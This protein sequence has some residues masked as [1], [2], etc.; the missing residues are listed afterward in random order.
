MKKFSLLLINIV[1]VV[2]SVPSGAR[3]VDQ[4]AVS[5]NDEIVLDSDVADFKKKLVSKSFKELFGGID[6]SALKDDRAILEL[7]IEERI[8]NQ[9]VKK[10]ELEATPQE[11]EGQIRS[12]LKRNGI[13]ENQLK[14]RLSQLGTTFAEYHN[15]IKRQL[16][17]NNLIGREIKPTLEISE[18]QL[19]HYFARSSRNNSYDA[20]FKIAHILVTKKGNSNVEPGARAQQLW[21]IVSKDPSQFQKHVAE[22]SDDTSTL[23][24]G[25]LLG[26]FPLSQLNKEF[27]AEVS[28]TPVGQV[29][30]PIKTSAGYHIILVMEKRAADFSVLSKEQKDALRNEMVSTELEKKMALWLER[31][32]TESHIKR[33]LN[34]AQ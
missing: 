9:Q 4:V 26:T 11:V 7:L 23:E 25:G 13:T 29:T 19:R 21:Q 12:I 31:K 28:K 1:M 34:A 30:K 32:K 14:Q 5:V 18:E 20:H 17:R 27:R 10:L 2:L 22:Y 3:I 8:I 33:Y 24:T 6:E 15:G 16:E